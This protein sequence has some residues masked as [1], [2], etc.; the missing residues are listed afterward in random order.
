MSDEAS[1]VADCA[2][3]PEDLLT[4]RDERPESE[5]LLNALKRNQDALSQLLANAL[6]PSVKK[7]VISNKSRRRRMRATRLL[8]RT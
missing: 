7:S 4:R 6:Y 2:P 8:L 5:A 1:D 3:D